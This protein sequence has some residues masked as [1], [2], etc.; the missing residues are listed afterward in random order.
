MNGKKIDMKTE[1]YSIYMDSQQKWR[2][3]D[4]EEDTGIGGIFDH[5]SDAQH[6]ADCRNSNHNMVQCDEWGSNCLYCGKYQK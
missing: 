6:Y 5:E 3:N 2:V 1:R 4:N